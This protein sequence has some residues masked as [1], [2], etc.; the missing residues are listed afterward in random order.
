MRS[1]KTTLYT[2]LTAILVGCSGPKMIPEPVLRDILRDAFISQAAATRSN[3]ARQKRVSIDTMDMHTPILKRYGYTLDD[4]RYTVRQMSVRKSNPLPN[5][6]EIVSADI[7]SVS[8]VAQARYLVKLK[9]DTLARNFTVDTVYRKDTTISGRIDGLKWAIRPPTG[10]TV[11]PVGTYQVRFEYSTGQSNSTSSK[12]LQYTRVVDSLRKDNNSMWLSRT[13]DTITFERN[14][15]IIHPEVRR[16]EFA[17]K[18]SKPTKGRIRDTVYL[19]NIQVVHTLP[20]ALANKIYYIHKSGLIPI[21]DRIE[22]ALYQQRLRE[23]AAIDS[24]ELKLR[25][26]LDSTKRYFDGPR[27]EPKI[28]SEHPLSTLSSPPQI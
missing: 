10:D 1:L 8:Q 12:T 27:R 17:F 23:L 26:C 22:T 19:R 11:L 9:I 14:I 20:T 7:K 3:Y 15:A 28:N 4:M 21:Q 13:K 16:L 6:L 18:E 25:P 24:A 2:L 5:I